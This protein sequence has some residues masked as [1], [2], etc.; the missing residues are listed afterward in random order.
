[1]FPGAP[2]AAGPG[3]GVLPGA[4]GAEL[5]HQAACHHADEALKTDVGIAHI[6]E[7]LVRRGTPDSALASLKSGE[8]IGLTDEQ[9]AAFA[10]PAFADMPT[11]T[12]QVSATDGLAVEEPPSSD[13]P[14]TD[15]PP[16]P[17]TT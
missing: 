10:A 15:P 5:D 2:V 11:S 7:V 1:M 16:S 14:P 17:P 6:S 9:K 13:A 3:A 8:N 4:L 12:G